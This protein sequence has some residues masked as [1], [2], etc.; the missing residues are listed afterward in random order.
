M[1]ISCF[2]S[3]KVCRDDKSTAECVM[4]YYVWCWNVFIIKFEMNSFCVNEK[5]NISF[6]CTVLR[7]SDCLLF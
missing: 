3:M 4:E 6:W 1:D 7:D 2:F 5:L